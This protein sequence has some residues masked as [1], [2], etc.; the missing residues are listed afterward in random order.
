MRA[1]GLQWGARIDVDGEDMLIE[2]V[3]K[4]ID[5]GPSDDPDPDEV[6]LEGRSHRTGQFWRATVPAGRDFTVTGALHVTTGE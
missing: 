2:S 3:W 1:D 5:T 4:R 6:I